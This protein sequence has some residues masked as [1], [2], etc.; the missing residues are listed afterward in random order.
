[1]VV[2][3]K[4]INRLRKLIKDNVIV[5]YGNGKSRVYGIKKTEEQKQVERIM[6]IK[7]LE[8]TIIK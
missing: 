6:A 4:T 5:S 2:G 3:Q 1:M 7:K 8:D